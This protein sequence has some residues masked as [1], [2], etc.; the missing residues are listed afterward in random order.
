MSS[1]AVDPIPQGMHSLTPHLVC[2]GAADAIEFYKRA[3]NAVELGRMPA[4]D[5]KLMHAMVK[6]GDS[7]LMLVDEFP[8]FGSVGPKA[9]KGSPV[10]IHLYVEDVDATVKQAESA[11]AKVTM[12][13]ADMFWG[14]RYG[15]LEDPF[16][17]QWSVATHKRDVTPEDMKQAMLQQPCQ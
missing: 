17:H 2:A 16:G 14:D 12:P 5:G 9:L 6:I 4:P 8:Q 11:G 7:M 13:V 15:R 1:P 10:T 3:F